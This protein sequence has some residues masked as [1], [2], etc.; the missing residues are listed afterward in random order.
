MMVIRKNKLRGLNHALV[1]LSQP[2]KISFPIGGIKILVTAGWG[3]NGK[4]PANILN[5]SVSQLI[6]YWFG[7]HFQ[8]KCFAKRKSSIK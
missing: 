4:Y 8:S 5:F 7:Y 3:F 2:G 6:A 1:I